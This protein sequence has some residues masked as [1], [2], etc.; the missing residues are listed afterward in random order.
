MAEIHYHEQRKFTTA[1]LLPY[2]E[3]HIPDL[4]QKDILEVGCAEAGFMAV[5]A[6][7]SFNISGIELMPDRVDIAK[8]KNPDLHITVGDI[9]QDTTIN[10]IGKTFDLIVMRDVIEH[11]PDRLA[12]FRNLNKL[13]KTNGYLY[14][15]FPPRFSG[16]AGHQQNAKSLLRFVPYLHLLPDG[17]IKWLGKKGKE[18]KAL[19]D[20]VVTNYKIGLTINAFE[21]HY[22]A[23]NFFAVIKELFIF[24]PIYQ[25]RFNLS[26]L[27]MI[28]LPILREFLAF[29]C[30]Y[31]LKKKQ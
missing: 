13:L 9:T 30:E 6:E 22:K 24:R 23:H 3:S 28:N 18:N 15:T 11:I 4:L 7:K 27:K 31:L 14:V 29:G 26:P 10:K 1:Y 2:L 8:E 16:F 25:Q 20:D 12:A 17:M 5:M 21:Q 19:I